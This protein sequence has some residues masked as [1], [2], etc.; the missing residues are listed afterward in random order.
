MIICDTG[1]GLSTLMIAVL[2]WL[3]KLEIWQIYLATAFSSLCKGFQFPA[4]ATTPTILVSKKDFGRANGMIQ[5]GQ[6]SGKLFSPMIA[7][8]LISI[9][10]LNGIILIDFATFIF[11]LITLLIARFPQIK[12]NIEKQA[13]KETFWQEIKY[14]W[15]Y[16]YLRPGLMILLMFF[17]VTDFAIGLAQVL[18]TPMVLSFTNAQVLGSI[19]SIGGSGW[20]IGAIIMSITGGPKHRTIDHRLC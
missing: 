9:I 19:L 6:A 14:G 15:H 13:K 16:L 12:N 8:V 4:Y 18:I 10:Q 3:G 17:V 7:G 11:A 1:A 20:L 5:L 2:L